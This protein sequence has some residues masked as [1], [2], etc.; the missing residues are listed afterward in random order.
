MIN[1]FFPFPSSCTLEKKKKHTK[2]TSTLEIFGLL[3]ERSCVRQVRLCPEGCLEERGGEKISQRSLVAL[4]KA[5]ALLLPLHMQL[6]K[7]HV[8]RH[9]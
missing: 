6:C 9:W 1:V 2:T 7:K 8:A 4:C 3:E 5:V